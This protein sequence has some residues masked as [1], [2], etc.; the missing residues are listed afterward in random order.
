MTDKQIF[1]KLSG[2]NMSIA[3]KKALIDVI[4]DIVNVNVNIDIPVIGTI[5]KDLQE[6]EGYYTHQ[7][8]ITPT[9]NT[10]KPKL[11]ELYKING[12]RR[13]CIIFYFSNY[14]VDDGESQYQS[15]ILVLDESQ[16]TIFG[17]NFNHPYICSITYNRNSNDIVERFY[18]E[19]K[20]IE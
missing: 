8:T 18:A 14:D 1:D 15:N 13:G 7:A 17:D 9:D 4:K 11:G 2:I 10:F 19:I 16:G 5:N 20:A 12:L 6:K 3:Q